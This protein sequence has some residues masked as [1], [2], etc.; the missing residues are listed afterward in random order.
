MCL[1]ENRTAILMTLL[2][3]NYNSMLT[4]VGE[5]RLKHESEREREGRLLL[6]S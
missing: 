1:H 3:I 6:Y 4:S 2:S 5:L